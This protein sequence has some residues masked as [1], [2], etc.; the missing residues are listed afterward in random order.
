M[1]AARNGVRT[2][3]LHVDMDQFVAAVEIRRRP[4]LRGRSVVVG[5]DGDPTRARQ[6][7]ATASYE[8]R[9][10]GVRS[11]MGL[12]EA[13]RRCPDAVFL[14]TDKPAYEAASAEVM[15]VL[16]DLPVVLEVQ[17]WDEA[18]LATR[19]D[20]P[21][22]V[23]AHIRAELWAISALSCTVGIGDTKQRAKL[24]A[25]AAK[26]TAPGRPPDDPAGIGRLDESTWLPTMGARPV[27]ALWG[28][29]ARWAAR[30]ADLG[31]RTVAELAAAD[32]GEL[33]ARLGPRTGPLMV[34]LARGGGYGPVTDTPWVARS[35][36]RETTYPADL[37]DPAD[38]REQ[39]SQLARHVTADVVADGRLVARVAVKLRTSTFFTRT[40]IT[41]LP[42]PTADPGA[43]VAAALAV[44]TRFEPDRAV[45]LL[46]VRAE[47]APAES[48]G[49]SAAGT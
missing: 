24:A 36:S 11:G 6:V 45:R 40:R 13:V 34:T 49:G 27:D 20:D 39:V 41:T 26:A 31:Y 10:F 15:A 9:A 30:L 3:I 35:R 47:L 42:T 2:W 43:V 14:P 5:G 16:R 4:E 32:P 8:A 28:I 33:A 25:Q 21:R 23:A 17:G 29:G 1:A 38:I 19:T 18:F 46:G 44:L 12:R 48:P 22:A 37:T 7:V